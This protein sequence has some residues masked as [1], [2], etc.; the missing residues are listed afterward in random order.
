MKQQ[1]PPNIPPKFENNLRPPN[2]PPKI[3]LIIEII[4]G[5]F[6]NRRLFSY[7]AAF[8]VALLAAL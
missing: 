6:G 7:S 2:I 5:M 8:L 1:R 4:G 3:P